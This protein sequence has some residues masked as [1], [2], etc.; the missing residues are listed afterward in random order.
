ML[1]PIITVAMLQ[2]GR[3]AGGGNGGQVGDWLHFAGLVPAVSAWPALNPE[4]AAGP[5]VSP[6]PAF[7]QSLLLRTVLPTVLPS[8]PLL[9]SHNWSQAAW[10]LLNRKSGGFFIRSY[11]LSVVCFPSLEAACELR[12]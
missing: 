9:K 10:G 11:E 8:L 12:L 5:R 2:R 1:I 7:A 6:A 3:H 4:C